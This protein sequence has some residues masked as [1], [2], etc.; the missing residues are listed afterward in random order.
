M[1]IGLIKWF[2]NQRW[3]KQQKM[4]W[5]SKNHFKKHGQVY[6]IV[7]YK[8]FVTFSRISKYK[9]E[10]WSSAKSFSFLLDVSSRVCLLFT[11]QIFKSFQCSP[12]TKKLSRVFVSKQV[13]QTFKP[14]PK[15][16]IGISKPSEETKKWVQ[17]FKCLV[18]CWAITRGW[19]MCLSNQE[20]VLFLVTRLFFI[21]SFCVFES[22]C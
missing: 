5:Y 6:E 19:T 20:K 12:V 15:Q 1:F 14:S 4:F 16:L 22:N 21:S 17:C 18:P 13:A 2:G 10:I 7:T 11:D 3:I 9:V 8:I